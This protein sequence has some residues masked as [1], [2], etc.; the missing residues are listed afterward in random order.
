[1]ALSLWR[2]FSLYNTSKRKQ[3]NKEIIA[4]SKKYTYKK[5]KA[6]NHIVWWVMNVSVVCWVITT[7]TKNFTTYANKF[8]GVFCCSCSFYHQDLA[9]VLRDMICIYQT[10]TARGMEGKYMLFW[11]ICKTW[12]NTNKT[13][14]KTC[15]KITTKFTKKQKGKITYYVTFLC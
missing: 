13:A 8:D 15:F 1:M 7:K 11:T 10:A 6:K 3:N 2:L 9:L 12:A 4:L 5:P 14:K